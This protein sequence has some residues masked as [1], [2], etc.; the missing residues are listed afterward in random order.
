LGLDNRTCEDVDECSDILG[1]C[2]GHP[3]TN[4]KGHFK[5]H[6]KEGYEVKE[7]KYCKL[8]TAAEGYL[9]AT[10]RRDIRTVSLG[11]AFPYYTH[12][13]SHYDDFY[14]NLRSAVAIDYS[15]T[16]NYLIW[17]DVVEEKMYIGRLNKSKS[18]KFVLGEDKQVL[19]GENLGIIDGLTIDYVHDLVY[20]TDTKSDRIEVAF[21]REPT[22]QFPEII[23]ERM[24]IVNT[25]LDEPRAIAVNVRDGY[26][27]WSD[28]GDHPK[29]ERSSQDGSDRRIIVEDNI[30][31]PNGLAIDYVTNNIY[32][33][34]VKLNT[35]EAVDFYGNNRRVILHNTIFVQHPFGIAVFEDNIYWSDWS[36][37]SVSKTNKFASNGSIEHVLGPL[38][39]INDLAVVHPKSQPKEARN[40]CAKEGCSHLCLPSGGSFGFKCLCPSERNGVKYSLSNDQ[41]SCLREDSSFWMD[42]GKRFPIGGSPSTL[43]QVSLDET[44]IP[45]VRTE[46]H[47]E[48][49]FIVPALFG[50]VAIVA[51]GCFLLSLI[52]Y[53]HYR[54]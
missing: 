40:R 38:Y 37:L 23:Q 22:A 8:K 16:G 31:W 4:T 21:L 10:T 34:D 54:R 9:L 46:E 26:L 3:C 19:I 42:S 6:C 36:T 43:D 35:I 29:I 41:R 47:Q 13:R 5:C 20:W 48:S 25:S 50:F 15:L 12:R 11:P 30:I 27:F 14:D 53:R 49:P 7:H 33:T 51:S 24:T 44:P 45:S 17:S 32:W 18:C 39:S 28:W 52:C 1:T 2:S